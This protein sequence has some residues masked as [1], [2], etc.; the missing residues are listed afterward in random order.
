MSGTVNI[1]RDIWNDTAFKPEPFT[2]REAFIWMVMEASYKPR[3]KPVG[4]MWVK[5]QRGQLVVSVRFMAKAWGWSKSKVDRFL[6]RLEKRD[7]IGTDIGTGINI[8]TICKYDKYQNNPIHSGTVNSEKR[9]SGGTAVGQQWDKPNKGLIKNAIRVKE[10]NK[11]SLVICASTSDFLDAVEIYNKAAKRVGWPECQSHSPARKAA[12]KSRLVECGG[13]E[14]WRVA[15]EK[16]AS[17]DFLT[18]KTERPFKANFD[19]IVKSANF[20]KIMEGNYENRTSNGSGQINAGS[21]GSK[22][23]I[24]SLVAQRRNERR[25]DLET[26]V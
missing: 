18:G 9:D 1:S 8:I 21:G 3:D 24:A 26:E 17:S 14:G 19:F 12:F 22:R 11:D 6:K 23:S 4:E 20:N 25:Y 2:E 13:M 16:A 5:L 10:E 7:T 15:I